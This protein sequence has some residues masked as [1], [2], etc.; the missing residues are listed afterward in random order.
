MYGHKAKLPL[1][2]QETNQ[3]IPLESHDQQ[4]QRHINFITE[5]LQQMRLQG[6]QNIE[7]AQQKQKQYHDQK[8]KSQKFNIEDKVLLYKLAKAKVHK[9][10]FREKWTE[11]YYIHDIVAFGIYKL[12]IIENKILRRAINIEKLK[13]YHE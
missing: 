6:Q 4:L 13:K 7:K 5:D 11:L 12:K 1:D 10:K 8:I 3:D 9:D 2:L